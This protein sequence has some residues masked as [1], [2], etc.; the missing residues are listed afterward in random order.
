MR[1]LEC[2]ESFMESLYKFL[3]ILIFVLVSI[4]ALYVAFL[5]ITYIDNTT[6]SGSK[7]GFTI[8]TSKEEV[9]DQI[10]LQQQ[11]YP[12]LYFYVRTG[13]QSKD[14]IEAPVKSVPLARI[15]NYERWELQFDGKHEYFN[16][17]KLTF[18]ENRLIEIHRHRKYFELP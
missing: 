13:K 4:L 6:T 18:V 10:I 15:K 9:Y 11:P 16:V 3:K 14:L 5:W 1:A 7:Y 12:D 17:L 2:F 8:G